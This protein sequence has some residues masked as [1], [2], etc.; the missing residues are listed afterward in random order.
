[1]LTMRGFEVSAVEAAPPTVQGDGDDAVLDLEITTNRPDCLSVSGIAREVSTIY[2]TE[3]RL[4]DPGTTRQHIDAEAGATVSVTIDE[5]DLCRRYVA[6]VANVTLG[7]SPSWLAARLDA[8][9]VRPIN[10]IVDITNYVMLETGHPMHAFD[11]ESLSGGTIIVRRAVAGETIKTLDGQE[12]PLGPTMLVIADAVRPQAVAGVMGGADSEVTGRSRTV[13]FES[14][15]FRPT[16]I[17]RTRKQLALSTDASYRF[18]RGTDIEGP[19]VAMR[20]ALT[21]LE[22]TQAGQSCG[23]TIDTYPRPHTPET[24][25]LRQARITRVLGVDIEA[26]FVVRSLERL[27]FT[28]TPGASEATADDRTTWQVGVPTH[29]VDVSREID[30]IEE[31]ARHYGYD[32]LMSTFPPVLQAPAPLSAWQRQQRLLR[33]VLTAGGSSEAITYSFTE[34]SAAAPFVSE[35]SDLVDIANPLSENFT[36]LRP[37]LLP[38]LLDALIRNRRREHRDIR[39]FEVGKRFRRKTGETSGVAIA[40]TGAG[41]LEHWSAPERTADFFDIKGLVERACDALGVKP[42]FEQT[43][44]AVLVPGRAARVWAISST[45]ESVS[46]GILGQLAPSIAAQRGFPSTGHEVYVAELDLDAIASVAID[47]DRLQVAP[48]PRHPSVVRD[49]ALIVDVTL[50]AAAVRDTIHTAAPETLVSVRE[51]DR[52]VGAGI[53]EWCVSLALRLTFR[54][55]DR[56]L[57]D[58]EVQTSVDAVVAALQDHHGATLR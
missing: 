6:A 25:T 36:V 11:L 10:N 24:L 17:R 58:V 8:A 44:N 28:V 49:L 22:Q 3:L 27:G 41:T 21:L 43:D 56:T 30:L 48:V 51:F 46:I 16:S 31:V 38:G 13:V 2:D 40:T 35:E 57:T 5:P 39:L 1:M 52:Y 42:Q 7:P 53:P 26:A 50:P 20:R 37:S 19:T 47:R 4:P 34:R 29:R 54:A 9:G 45:D 14:A 23:P 12:R 32:H 33:R 18:E 55:S 15:Y